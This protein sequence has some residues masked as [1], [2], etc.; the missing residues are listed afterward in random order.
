MF[1]K[2]CICDMHLHGLLDHFHSN[3]RWYHFISSVHYSVCMT[4]NKHRCVYTRLH[5]STHYVK[6]AMTMFTEIKTKNPCNQFSWSLRR[7]N[8]IEM[9]FDTLEKKWNRFIYIDILFCLRLRGIY[10]LRWGLNA[11]E[12]N[13]VYLHVIWLISLWCRRQYIESFGQFQSTH[14]QTSIIF[15]TVV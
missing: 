7:W 8:E 1:R 9:K 5:I 2:W 10:C 4:S 15:R 11:N 3:S 6:H 14:T 12:E 13:K